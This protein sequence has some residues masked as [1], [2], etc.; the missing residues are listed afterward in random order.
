MLFYF[1]DVIPLAGTLIMSNRVQKEKLVN[2]DLLPVDTI[3]DATKRRSML[4]S[5]ITQRLSNK[6]DDGFAHEISI[7][8][9]FKQGKVSL[10][11]VKKH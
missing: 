6:F 8:K 2:Q 4:M 7:K 10:K 1:L 3:E 5:K 9:E 11:K